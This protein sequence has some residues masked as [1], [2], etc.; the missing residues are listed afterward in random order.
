MQLLPDENTEKY[1]EICFRNY[2]DYYASLIERFI[3][4][5]FIVLKFI[6]LK[7]YLLKNFRNLIKLKL[8]CNLSL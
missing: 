4:S 6:E 3:E 1:H 5:Q 8:C 2:E 7:R